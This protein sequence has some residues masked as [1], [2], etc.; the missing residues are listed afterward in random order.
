MR[1]RLA[2]AVSGQVCS[3]REVSLAHK[4]AELLL[5][6]PKGTVPVLVLPNGVVIDQSLD[7]M[8]WALHRNDPEHWLPAQGE[9]WDEAVGLISVCD[10]T[11]KQHLDHYKYPN[12]YGLSNGQEGRTLG[13]QFL[14]ELNRRL[15]IAPFLQ[16]GQWGLADAAIAPFVRQYAHTDSTWF[17]QQ[18]WGELQ[19]WLSAFEASPDY[20]RAMQKYPQWV[21]VQ[22][23]PWPP[24]P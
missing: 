19:K 11:F 16:G 18:P 10:S 12:R 23:A 3:L 22:T 24:V 2:I 1:A 5:A 8:M 6:S 13:A 4:P 20:H 17:A 7:I 14:E 21:P 9:P 15:A